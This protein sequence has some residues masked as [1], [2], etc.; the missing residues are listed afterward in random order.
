MLIGAG[1]KEWFDGFGD[2]LAGKMAKALRPQL[3]T[4]GFRGKYEFY[5]GRGGT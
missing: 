1:G 5:G 2:N 4:W 3:W